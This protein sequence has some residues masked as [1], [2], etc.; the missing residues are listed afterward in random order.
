MAFK[1]QTKFFLL[2][3]IGALALSA[4]NL[5][6]GEPTPTE[7]G[8]EAVYTA[9]AQTVEAQFTSAA[10]A[11]PSATL[12]PSP[13]G[14]G[15]VTP[16]LEATNTQGAVVLPTSSGGGGSSGA[17]GCNNSA[18]VS[19]VTVPDNQQIAPGTS[20]T[21]TWRVQNTGT[22]AW[23]ANYKLTFISGDAMGGATTAINQTVNA[24]ASADVSVTLTAPS[25][26]KTYIGYWKLSTDG[27]QA[28]GTSIYV[29]IVVTGTPVTPGTPG[30]GLP[31]ITPTFGA[32][33]CYNSALV[34]ATPNDGVT[35]KA[36]DSFRKTW[37]IKNT[38]TCEWNSDFRFSFVS[39]EMMRDNTT[40]KLRRGTIK[41]GSN[42]EYFLDFTAPTAPGT[43]SSVWRLVTDGGTAFGPSF[44]LKIVVP[45]ATHTSTVAPSIT[46]T[47]TVTPTVTATAPA[48]P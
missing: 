36:G 14:T 48:Y 11:Q 44:T 37:V 32:S 7:I 8:I 40:N 2:L 34:S 42:V 23:N 41:P 35:I 25:T 46:P 30:T 33:G 20:F 1:P 29:Q 38:G 39:G 21:K 10:A 4:C 28:F 18:Y 27:G 12:T 19:D 22:C 15:T 26:A 3:M 5:S 16:T 17:V 24:G 13:T 45:G 9:A 6:N 47:P 31:T 43:Y